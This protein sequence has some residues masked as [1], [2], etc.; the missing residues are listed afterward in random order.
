VLSAEESE[1]PPQKHEE[2]I[3]VTATRSERAVSELP[4]STT[5]VGEQEIQSTPAH[6]IDDVLR[7]IPG[8]NMPLSTALNNTVQSQRISMRGLGG[9]RALVLLDGVPMHDPFYGT[10]EWQKVPLDTLKQA[11]VVRGAN[12]SLFGNFALGGTI[13]LLTRPVD[14]SLVRVDGSYG[15]N[16]TQHQ[17][18]SVDQILTDRLSARLSHN[19]FSTN[20][21]YRQ[22]IP[23]N[24]DV[25]GWNDTAITS[26]RLEFKPNDG[27]TAYL[28]VDSSQIDVS[29]GTRLSKVLRDIT[30]FATGVQY[31]LTSNSLLSTSV[32]HQRENMHLFSSGTIGNRE[33][34]YVS[35]DSRIPG[36]ATGASLEWSTQR[37]GSVPFLS[38]GVDVQDVKADE[39]G[40]S[41][42]RNGVQTLHDVVGGHQKF[43]GV[44]AQVSWQPIDR[45]EV[46]S[47]A[48]FD[49][50]SNVGQQ[51]I[52]GGALNPYPSAESK[53]F[54]PRVSVR[55][56]L[57]ARSAIR[58][59]AYRGF[60]APTL[61]E[62]YR[63]T[64]SG[65]TQLLANPYLEPETLLGADLGFEWAAAGTH[66]E[67]NVF[68]NDIDGLQVRTPVPGQG[69]NVVRNVNVGTGRSQ[70]IEAMADVRLSQ[71]WSIDAGYAYTDSTILENKIDPTLE[72]KQV[73]DV[74][75]HMGSLSIRF[76]ALSGT[77]IDVRGRVLSRSYGEPANVVPAPAHRI[78]DVSVSQ[79]IRSWID[80]YARLE[81]AFDEQ[82]FYVLTPTSFRTGQSRAFSA[83]MR[84]RFPTSG[85][86]R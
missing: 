57:G 67:L 61:R 85:W 35:T 17:S 5:V 44:F 74:P 9:T 62:L 3:V 86:W 29:Q 25:P 58:A 43:A 60:K 22:P 48:R 13:N 1:K 63:N 34:E 12:A 11:E 75:K 40:I 20:G 32:F 15:T 66:V 33:N 38:V 81:N 76:H 59:A 56:G 6:T 65:I 54:D 47:S 79:P 16:A 21:T 18:L 23:G 68:R 73:P 83:G 36:R 53:Q 28:K 39:D 27:T 24:I 69:P 49:Y 26:A 55:Y 42:N 14:A 2:T 84:M 50:F 31:A 4:I 77:S 78:V 52:V 80:A 64:Q 8:I 45:L 71:R 46:L 7:T 70:G 30:D 37:R 19:R 41:Y 82:Y 10:V 72:G 51:Q